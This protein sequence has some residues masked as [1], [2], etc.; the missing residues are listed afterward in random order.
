MLKHRI[1]CY[2]NRV[3]YCRS[4]LK[5]STVVPGEE[6]VHEDRAERTKLSEWEW[7]TPINEWQED[8][9]GEVNTR[10]ILNSLIFCSTKCKVLGASTTLILVYWTLA[11]QMKMLNCEVFR[12][13][14]MI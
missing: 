3:S 7:L 6:D 4:I 14:H 2:V 8:G 1:L 5:L 11:L 13:T 12:I 9:G 10:K